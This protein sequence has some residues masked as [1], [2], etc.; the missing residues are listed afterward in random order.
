MTCVCS[1][2]VVAVLFP[3]LAFGKA[4]EDRKKERERQELLAAIRAAQGVP[5]AVPPPPAPAGLPAIPMPLP[6]RALPQGRSTAGGRPGQPRVRP[7]TP[8]WPGVVDDT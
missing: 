7:P 8:D 1:L 5:P 4:A 3:L 6:T 2:L